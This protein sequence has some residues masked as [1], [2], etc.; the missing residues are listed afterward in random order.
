M[1]PTG[2]EADVIDG[3]EVTCIDNGM[4]T[5]VMR[6][7]D[8]E[9]AGDETREELEADA[10][11][12][13]RLESIRLRAGPMMNLGDVREKTVPKMTMVSPPRAGG[14]ISTRTFI[15]HRCHASIGLL[16]AV[17]VGTACTLPG[18]PA[19]A[20]A[21]IPEG[22]PKELR[23]EHPIGET[24]IVLEMDSTGAVESAAILRTARKLFD[25]VVFAY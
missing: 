20:L 1:L 24:T 7:T 3:I 12:K 10:G 19:A 8:M 22:C 15:P 9:I 25:G 18:S 14:A 17:S 5:V 4:P 2:K 23:I 11:L 6:A 13:A 16:G 21:E